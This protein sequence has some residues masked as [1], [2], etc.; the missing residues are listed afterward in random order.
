MCRK[1]L[2]RWCNLCLHSKRP[3][4]TKHCPSHVSPGKKTRSHIRLGVLSSW[5]AAKYMYKGFA[6]RYSRES[7]YGFRVTSEVTSLIVL[8]TYIV[9]YK[10]EAMAALKL[11]ANLTPCSNSHSHW[12][13]LLP[14]A[15]TINIEDLCYTKQHL[16]SFKIITCCIPTSWSFLFCPWQQLQLL[17][18]YAALLSNSRSCWSMMLPLVTAAA[19]EAWY[20]P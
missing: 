12:R 2:Y 15:T 19:I 4:L 9:T 7:C 18:I 5:L 20:C 16:K 6:R 1:T 8:L 3:L 10:L 11:H 13:L 14:L 17:K